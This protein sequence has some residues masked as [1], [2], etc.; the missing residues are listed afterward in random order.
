MQGNQ[1]TART[2]L[3]PLDRQGAGS[4]RTGTTGVLGKTRPDRAAQLSTHNG[5]RCLHET[6][7]ARVHPPTVIIDTRT[8]AVLERRQPVE[9]VV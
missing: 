4:V 9:L 5:P 8:T 2:P 7:P 6:A 1:R 3:T